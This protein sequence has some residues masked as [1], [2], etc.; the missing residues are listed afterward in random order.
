MGHPL[1]FSDLD[2]SAPGR[3]PLRKGLFALDRGAV[4]FTGMVAGAV[5]ALSF[6]TDGKPFNRL[7]NP[8]QS[9]QA[10]VVVKVSGAPAGQAACSNQF[11]FSPKVIA[12]LRS[13]HPLRIGVIGDS[14][15]EG[16]A[17]A[18]MLH[19]EKNPDFAVYQFT[20]EATG[21]T[22][23]KTLDLFQDARSRV[24]AQPI[25]IALIDFG[26][27]DTQGVFVDGHAAPYMSERWQTIIGGRATA[28]V[29]W[30]QGQGI[31]VG[32]VGLPRMR[33]PEFDG[34]IQ[35]MN[36]FYAGLMCK[37]HVPFVNPVA[38]SED[39]AHQFSKE[40]KDPATGAL[41]TA[42]ADDG[43]HMSVHGYRVIAGPLFERIET[44]SGKGDTGAAVSAHAETR[45]EAPK[46]S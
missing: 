38:V 10:P 35:A 2:G 43:I 11:P 41:Y 37:L 12:G 6:L 25:D 13:G 5:L 39:G 33:K 42:R 36:A 22:R 34:D 21:F 1:P 40:L 14:F 23:Y 30:L 18:A 3:R 15:G 32:W 20:R 28:L 27:N 31:A 19:F 7:L 29:S 8:G 45:A 16:I 17:Q 9:A 24:A 44:L 46:E 4:L 26:A